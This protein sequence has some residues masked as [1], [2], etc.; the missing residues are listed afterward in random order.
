MNYKRILNFTNPNLVEF[1]TIISVFMLILIPGKYVQPETIDDVTAEISLPTIKC[2]LCVK[3]VSK[4]LNEVKG[5]RSFSINLD[6]LKAFVTYSDTKT[7]LSKILSA[8]TKAGYDANNG[9]ADKNAYDKLDDCC[10][11]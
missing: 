1:A 8:I 2:E 5:I 4:A 11:T 10:K 7:N 3:T 6:A 9:R